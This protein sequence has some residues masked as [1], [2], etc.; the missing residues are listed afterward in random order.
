M[1]TMPNTKDQLLY[2]LISGVILEH[3]H[4]DLHL[5]KTMLSE[6]ADPA[7]V[8]G[9]ISAYDLI[10]THNH[11]GKYNSILEE[12]DDFLDKKHLRE[13]DSTYEGL[14]GKIEE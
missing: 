13:H 3:S 12:F 1:T 14:E 6:G 2:N 11:D 4:I 10:V 9:D 7:A 5:I 8:V